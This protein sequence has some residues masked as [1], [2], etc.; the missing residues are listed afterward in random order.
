[1]WP[2][3]LRALLLVAGHRDQLA[4][5][6]LRRAH[7]DQPR[8]GADQLQHLVAHGADRPRPAPSPRRSR[9]G[10]TGAS[11]EVG[12]PL[13]DPLLARAVHELHLVVPVVLQV[14][15][16]VGGEP[17][18]AVAVEH[19]RVVVR[20][21]A[22]AE[23]LAEV[24]R[25]EEVA[26]HLVLEVLLPVEADR[27][28]D[29]RLRVERRVLVHLDDP[30]RVVVEVVLDPLRVDQNVLRVV[31]HGYLLGAVGVGKRIPLFPTTFSRFVR[32]SCSRASAHG[33]A[34]GSSR[35]RTPTAAR[36]TRTR[37]SAA[38]ARPAAD[39]PPRDR[40]AG[41]LCR[42]TCSLDKAR[43]YE[44]SHSAQAPAPAA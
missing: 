21:A 40:P 34:S 10:A 19:D 14:P 33:C 36:R 38:A 6:L 24:L 13:R 41:A 18:V 22:R 3:A 29:V 12:P 9:P 43:V 42:A 32:E 44:V 4:G 37:C 30:D 20:D 39:P 31:G 28:R 15:V 7:V 27:A 11:V 23:Q 5:E 1:M 25:P 35:A 17:V 8:V 16:G 2:A 26:L